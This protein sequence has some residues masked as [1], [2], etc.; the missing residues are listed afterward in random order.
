VLLVDA[1]RES[2]QLGANLDG[3]VVGKLDAT[4]AQ[5]RRWPPSC[6]L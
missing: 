6:E 5:I 2:R 1:L 4:I 3:Y